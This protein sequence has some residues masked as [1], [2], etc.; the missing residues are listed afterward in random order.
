MASLSLRVLLRT[1]KEDARV[2]SWM[3]VARSERHPL[4]SFNRSS[5]S[6]DSVPG[7]KSAPNAAPSSTA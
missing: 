1:F 5:T 4:Y 6:D 3:M 7:G 2:Y